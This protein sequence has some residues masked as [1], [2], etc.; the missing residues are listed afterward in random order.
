MQHLRRR[1][2]VDGDCSRRRGRTKDLNLRFYSNLRSSHTTLLTRKRAA[3]SSM[4]TASIAYFALSSGR[5]NPSYGGEGKFD[6]QGGSDLHI[7]GNGVVA[8]A[9]RIRACMFV[10]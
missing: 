5:Y 10:S 7:A 1:W 2:A 3:I 8:W 4:V 9:R 6:R